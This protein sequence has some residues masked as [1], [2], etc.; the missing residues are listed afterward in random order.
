MRKPTLTVVGVTPTSDA[1][2]GAAWPAWAGAAVL[3]AAGPAA[4]VEPAVSPP[5]KPEVAT[6]TPGPA[7]P[8]EVV[9]VA[10]AVAASAC[11]AAI[12]TGRTGVVPTATRPDDA[13]VP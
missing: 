1:V 13:G 6:V 11:G 7:G 5:P 4:A 9:D 3:V 10:E 2:S 8:M 12:P